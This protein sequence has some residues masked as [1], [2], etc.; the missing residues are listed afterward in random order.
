MF[1]S[2]M[3]STKGRKIT[4][5]RIESLYE[6]HVSDDWKNWLSNCKLTFFHSKDNVQFV[7]NPNDYKMPQNLVDALI[8]ALPTPPKRR[9]GSENKPF[10]PSGLKELLRQ[11]YKSFQGYTLVSIEEITDD[12]DTP[13]ISDDAETPEI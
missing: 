10:N 1:D 12:I 8:E 4:E 13:E 6:H 7:S 2:E 11:N 5:T 9:A 3:Q